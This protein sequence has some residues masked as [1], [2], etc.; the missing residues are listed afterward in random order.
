VAVLALTDAEVGQLEG[1]SLV[2]SIRR[3]DV[4]SRRGTLEM[5]P[6]VS[7]DE[8]NTWDPDHVGPILIPKRGLQGRLDAR[9]LALYRR[10]IAVYEGHTLEQRL[11]GGGVARVDGPRLRAELS[12]QRLQRRFAPARQHEAGAR[13][14][15]TAG[16]G[17]A[18]AAGAADENVDGRDFRLHGGKG[19]R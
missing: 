6:N 3:V 16:G 2:E 19:R 7:D 11:D 4:S 1:G 18:D 17:G 9:N 8:F 5:F 14:G 12:G 10:A 15:E 13:A